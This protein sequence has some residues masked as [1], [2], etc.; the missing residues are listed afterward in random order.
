MSGVSGENVPPVW[1]E[2]VE[3]EH[4]SPGWVV[5]VTPHPWQD[6]ES[7][8][9]DLDRSDALAAQL[10]ADGVQS[11][12]SH[13]RWIGPVKVKVAKEVGPPPWRFPRIGVWPW[14]DRHVGFS[15]LIGWRST[16]YRLFMLWAPKAS[17]SGRRPE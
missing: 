3:R 14:R 8:Q 10:L 15:A 1:S 6:E 7:I 4:R 16:A 5:T 2:N 11:W 17:H 12:H 9:A 13:Y